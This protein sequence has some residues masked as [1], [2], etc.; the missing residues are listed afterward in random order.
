MVYS[1][2]STEPEENEQVID[3]FCR[4]HPDFHREHVGSWLPSAGLPLITPQ[5]D[6]STMG[7]NFSMD[8][9]YA[10]CLQKER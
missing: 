10:A 4:A 5:G 1:T 8:G 7:N 9:F 2:C 6:F 3:K